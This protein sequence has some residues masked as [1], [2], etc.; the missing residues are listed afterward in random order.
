MPC[1]SVCSNSRHVH[2]HVA[3]TQIVFRKG[4]LTACIDALLCFRGDHQAIY[5]LKDFVPE[6]CG[7]IEALCGAVESVS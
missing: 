7:E 4:L 2:M 1:V 5:S 6:F 3:Y